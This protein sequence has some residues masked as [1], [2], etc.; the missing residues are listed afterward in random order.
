MLVLSRKPGQKIQL[1]NCELQVI[2]IGR[3]QVRLG[4]TAPTDLHIVRSELLDRQQ[5][6]DDQPPKAA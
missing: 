1:G 3:G 5:A 4:F 2:Q 6:Q